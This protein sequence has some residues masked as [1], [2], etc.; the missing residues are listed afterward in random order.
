MVTIEETPPEKVIELVMPAMLVDGKL[1]DSIPEPLPNQ[2]SFWG[3][4]GPPR[5]GKSSAVIALLTGHYRQVFHNVIYIVPASSFASVRDNPLAQ[6]KHVYHEFDAETLDDVMDIVKASSKKGH[7]T[8]VLVD[9]FMTAL[10]D[11][12][13]RRQF[14]KLVANRRHLRT[15]LWVISQNY[16]ALPLSTRKLLS[17][18]L[19]FRPNNLRE[20]ESFRSELFPM[21]RHDFQVIFN[22]VFASGNKHDFMFVD[23]DAGE[24]HKKWTRLRIV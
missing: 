4:F 2:A 19:F 11:A 23:V 10:K 14:E 7:H 12:P 20:T 24:I 1:S 13:L 3:F 22:H 18:T 9:D 6:V 8:L 17:H 16:I 15:S 21:S 5:S